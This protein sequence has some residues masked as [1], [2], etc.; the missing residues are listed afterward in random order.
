MTNIEALDGTD[1]TITQG[2][3]GSEPQIGSNASK[4]LFFLGRCIANGTCTFNATTAGQDVYVQVHEFANVNPAGTTV[5]TVIENSTHGGY[6]NTT[7]NSTTVADADV[8]TLGANRLAVNIVGI[9]DDNNVIAF[10]GES[11]GDWLLRAN[12]IAAAGTDAAIGLQTASMPSTGTISGGTYTQV[13]DPWGTI[14]FAFKPSTPDSTDARTQVSWVEVEVP[15]PTGAATMK[16]GT[17]SGSGADSSSLTAVYP[18]TETGGG[19]DTP[20]LTAALGSTDTGSGSEEGGI[21][22]PGSDSGAGVD[23]SSLAASY[24]PTEAGSGS[25]VGGLAVT[26]DF[27]EVGAGVETGTVSVPVTGTDAGT[28]VDNSVLTAAYAVTDAATGADVLSLAANYLVTETGT[29][30]DSG[31]VVTDGGV[32]FINASDSGSGSDTGT[33]VAGVSGTDSG[34]GSENVLLTV[35]L[36]PVTE[37]GVGSDASGLQAAYLLADAGVGADALNAL[38][39]A[40]VGSDEGTAVEALL[41]QA[42]ITASETGTAVEVGTVS[43]GEAIV[44]LRVEISEGG[45]TITPIS[46]TVTM[47]EIQGK[48]D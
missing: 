43:F 31:S 24:S 27:T 29:G 38:A 15:E 28:G 46:P 11:G 17:D 39:A 6:V 14:G 26:L 13:T 25:D 19:S 8:T 37:S 18:T 30:T 2:W 47:N 4:L 36:A 12:F 23:S 42:I 40:L 22:I 35:V 41:T 32:T 7:G 5:A 34:I 45:A 48:V 9:N 33:M 10:T 21:G 16:S 44:G 3:S 20:V 1:S